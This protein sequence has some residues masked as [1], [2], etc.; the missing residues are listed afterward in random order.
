M[1]TN[2]QGHGL[3]ITSSTGHQNANLLYWE[4]MN[5][6]FPC[7]TGTHSYI[8]L[9]LWAWYR[10]VEVHRDIGECQNNICD[11][12]PDI[13]SKDHQLYFTLLVVSPGRLYVRSSQECARS[14]WESHDLCPRAQ[15]LFCGVTA[16]WLRALSLP[17][18]ASSHIRCW[19]LCSL[20]GT[21]VFRIVLETHLSK[22]SCC[23]SLLCDYLL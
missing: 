3:S 12:S 19:D 17:Y 11:L 9:R 15:L 21:S 23:L 2:P 7:Q 1:T 4:L 18:Q 6:N 20:L 8:Y 10:W 5:E 13:R 14:S 16:V 22:A